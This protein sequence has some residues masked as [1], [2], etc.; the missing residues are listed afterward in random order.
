MLFIKKQEYFCDDACGMQGGAK[1]Q[2]EKENL[3]I[4]CYCYWKSEELNILWVILVWF[5]LPTKHSLLYISW[6]MQLI[7]KFH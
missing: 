7:L 6:N 4:L 2:V 1:K 3:P 5:V